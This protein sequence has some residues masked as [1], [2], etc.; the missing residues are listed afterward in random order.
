M[1]SSWAI[2]ILSPSLFET[3]P[4]AVCRADAIVCSSG[5]TCGAAQVGTYATAHFDGTQ[6]TPGDNP[7]AGYSWNFQD[8]ASAATAAASHAFATVNTFNVSLT[9]TDTKGN[10]SSAVCPVQVTDTSLPPI[11]S[12]GGPYTICQGDSLILD[13]SHSVGRGSDIVAYA[14]DWTAPINFAPADANVVDTGNLGPYFSGLSV[15]TYDVALKVT[16]NSPVPFHATAFST[17]TVVRAD[18]PSCNQPPVANAG[19]DQVLECTGP[20]T[21]LVFNGS[22]SSDPDGD[23]LTYAWTF[24][25]GTTSTGISPVLS[26]HLGFTSATLVVHDGRVASAA[27]A[28]S[29]T[30]MDTTPPDIRCPADVV[31]QCNGLGV[32]TG[33]DPGHATATELCSSASIAEPGLATYTLGSTTVIT[34]TAVDIAGNSAACTNHVSV[35]D[36]LAPVMACPRIEPIP[37]DDRCQGES[38]AL[39]TGTDVC[40]DTVDSSK[41]GSARYPLGT[42]IETYTGVDNSGNSATCT[43]AITVV[44]RTPPTL[45]CAPDATV[46]TDAGACGSSF[47]PAATTAQDN[48]DNN[49]AINSDQPAVF[50]LGTSTVHATTADAAGNRSRCETQ[51]TVVD[52]EKPAI[53]CPANV[54]VPTDAGGCGAAVTLEATATDNCAAVT[55]TNDSPGTFAAGTTTTVHFTATDAAGNVNS[56]STTVTVRD[57]TSP[58]YECPAPVTVASEALSC[59]KVV[60]LA[61]TATDNCDIDGSGVTIVSDHPS[62]TIRDRLRISHHCV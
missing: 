22:A 29:V 49:V 54:S 62:T 38:N 15:G 40:D 7:I 52:R 19:A 42:T 46:N 33:V 12:A 21:S 47:K 31:A 37:A 1:G 24:G 25:D 61:A 41:A 55:V 23:A 26:L 2:I 39:A 6:S 57:E 27:D 53:V 5:A 59:G 20:T 16:D 18:D 14:W 48:C 3:P 10:S 43:A 34:H 30:I 9:V 11:A 45:T 32:A 17:V 50:P 56:C 58:V 60:A 13:G 4:S 8:G 51:I 28:T 44:D 36:S 35:R